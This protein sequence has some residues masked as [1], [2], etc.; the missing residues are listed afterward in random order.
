MNTYHR[1]LLE[2]ARRK[3]EPVA[4]RMVIPP[5]IDVHVLAYAEREGLTPEEAVAYLLKVGMGHERANARPRSER[6]VD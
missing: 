4:R 3:Q 1:R 5:E 2:D 6:E